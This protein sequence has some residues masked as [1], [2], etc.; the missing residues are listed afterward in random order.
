MSQIAKLFDGTSKKDVETLT[1]DTGGAVGVDA[2][3]NINLLTGDGLTSTGVPASNTLT[4]TLDGYAKGTG[5]TIGAVT[6]DLITIAL[7][8]TPTAY[9]VEAKIAGFESTTPAGCGYNVICTARTTGAAAS[10]V[11]TQDKIV[12]EEAALAGC[13]VNF[14]VA[15]NNLILRATGTAGLTVNWSSTANRVGV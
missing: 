8:A 11:G 12:E 4:F 6:A 2:A 9:I 5:Q 13:D 1:G 14:V 15:A 10:L 7:G 3:F